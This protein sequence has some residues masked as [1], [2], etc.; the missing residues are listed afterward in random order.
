MKM[1][2]GWTTEGLILLIDLHVSRSKS[3][4]AEL[5]GL[6]QPT[7]CINATDLIATFHPSIFLVLE[8]RISEIV[9]DVICL[10]LGRRDWVRL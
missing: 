3:N 4:F 10:R 7:V 9:A 1:V 8:P 2:H 6:P 5:Q